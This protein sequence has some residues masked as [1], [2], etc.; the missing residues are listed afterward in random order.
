MSAIELPD[1]VISI[2][3]S[4]S[5]SDCRIVKVL[6]SPAK[7]DNKMRWHYQPSKMPR[8]RTRRKER[9][10]TT[11]GQR[12]E[13]VDEDNRDMAFISNGDGQCL[14]T[15]LMATLGDGPQTTNQGNGTQ[16]DQAEPKSIEMSSHVMAHGDLTDPFSIRQH[17]ADLGEAGTSLPS[18]SQTGETRQTSQ[19]NDKD[20]QSRARSGSCSSASTLDLRLAGGADQQASVDGLQ[21]LMSQEPSGEPKQAAIAEE[22]PHGAQPAS[23]NICVQDTESLENTLLQPIQAQELPTLQ[24]HKQVSPR[25]HRYLPRVGKW[26][27]WKSIINFAG[28]EALPG[29]L[30]TRPKKEIHSLTYDGVVEDRAQKEAKRRRVHD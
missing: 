17:T 16:V 11:I 15:D 26:Q 8:A 30:F 12:D 6:P 2:S 24:P 13:A 22:I 3:S 20:R 28:F 1:D 10:T 25:Q 9:E 4:D 27:A 19:S 7:K 23:A 5:D 21:S 18:L 29:P 14:G